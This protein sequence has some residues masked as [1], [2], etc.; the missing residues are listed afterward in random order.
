TTPEVALERPRGEAAAGPSAE[1]PASPRV[2]LVVED[3]LQTNLNPLL[4]DAE[5]NLPPRKENPLPDP[6][7]IISI[8]SF[9]VT[10]G[11]M[12][13]RG[14]TYINPRQG[15]CI[16]PSLSS[17]SWPIEVWDLVTG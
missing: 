13:E 8:E 5:D 17:F 7:F 10:H 15:S 6:K 14:P 12:K 2:P 9:T 16:P 3:A 11:Q 1:G 4:L